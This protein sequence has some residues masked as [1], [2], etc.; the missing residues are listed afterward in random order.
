MPGGATSSQ[1]DLV[2]L[3]VARLCAALWRRDDFLRLTRRH[4]LRLRAVKPGAK[5]V[6]DHH[7]GAK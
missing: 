6:A 5:R 3:P 1:C 2:P 7:Q 4:R